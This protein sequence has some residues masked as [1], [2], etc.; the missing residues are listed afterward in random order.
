MPFC[1]QCG[2]QVGA[3]ARF[4]G[5]CGSAQPAAGAGAGY[6]AAASG[7]PSQP[8]QDEVTSSL[9]PQVAAV[10]CYAPWFG[11]I[12]ALFV[13]AT[14]RFRSMRTVRF[15]AFQGLYLF[16]TWML[17]DL[18]AKEMVNSSILSRLLRAS[19]VITWVYMMVQTYQGRLLKLP[20]LGELA[21]RSVDEQR[22]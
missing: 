8:W 4:C 21:D 22:F 2:S 1:P 13:L 15:H 17:V 19:V 20:F 12:A 5:K 10:L 18:V 9:S 14:E 7:G 11:W 16:V 6:R 3:E